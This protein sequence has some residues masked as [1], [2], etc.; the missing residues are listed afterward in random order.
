MRQLAESDY[1][2]TVDL[3]ETKQATKKGVKLKSFVLVA[4]ISY[5]GKLTLDEGDDKKEP[6]RAFLTGSKTLIF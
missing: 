6:K 5:A 4:K 3:V 1:F 2:Q